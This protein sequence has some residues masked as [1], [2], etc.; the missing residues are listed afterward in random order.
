MVNHARLSFLLAASAWAD[1]AIPT[2]KPERAAPQIGSAVL[3]GLERLVSG[4]GSKDSPKYAAQVE[5]VEILD[6]IAAGEDKDAAE[7]FG[8]EVVYA[9]Y[10]AASCSGNTSPI[11]S[12]YECSEAAES[13]WSGTGCSNSERWNEVEVVHRPDYP[14]GCFL[15]R[16]GDGSCSLRY[17]GK[18]TADSC[19]AGT[20][21]VACTGLAVSRRETMI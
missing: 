16:A 15:L 6:L 8:A 13:L 2:E 5:P 17:N 9:D 21:Q 11:S 4:F 20:C 10:G 12:T 18:G 3:Y 1:S 19:T 14:Q 7:N